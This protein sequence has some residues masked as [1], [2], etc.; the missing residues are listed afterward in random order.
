MFRKAKR[1]S[2]RLGINKERCTEKTTSSNYNINKSYSL[3]S[4]QPPPLLHSGTKLTG[5]DDY[6]TISSESSSNDEF[7]MRISPTKE[8][9]ILGKC[10][11]EPNKK[12][13]YDTPDNNLTSRLSMIDTGNLDLLL[14]MET[15]ARIEAQAKREQEQLE[16]AQQQETLSAPRPTKIKFELPVTPPRSRSPTNP[17]LQYPRARP[18]RSL[19]E[20]GLTANIMRHPLPNNNNKNKRVGWRH[21]FGDRDDEETKPIPLSITVGSRVK[22]KLRPLPTFGFVR[23]IGNV[24]PENEEY[25]GVELDHGVG[26]CDGTRNGKRYF[27]TDA[28]RGIYCTKRD[29]E[30]VPE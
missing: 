8:R 1:L 12:N 3:A 10:Q 7:D 14:S 2:K 26:N 30:A 25:V 22:L 5:S 23:F 17:R 27:H 13:V 19:P 6:D 29:L 11:T 16:Q 24:E 9:P 20:E 15:Q 4:E 18:V 28:N 21:L